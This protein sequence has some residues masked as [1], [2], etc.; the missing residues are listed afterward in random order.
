[1]ITMVLILGIN[2]WLHWICT[3]PAPLPGLIQGVL[4]PIFLAILFLLLPFILKGERNL[5][6]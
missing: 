1:M 6:F 3:L 5:L 4:P 2:S